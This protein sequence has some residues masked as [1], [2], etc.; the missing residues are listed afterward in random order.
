MECLCLCEILTGGLTC[1]GGLVL[2]F[3]VH[4]DAIVSVV[5]VCFVMEGVNH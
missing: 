1:I 3:A 5:V 2:L 4:R